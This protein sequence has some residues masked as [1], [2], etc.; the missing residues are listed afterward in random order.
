MFVDLC[1][2]PVK[3]PGSPFTHEGFK[4]VGLIFRDKGFVKFNFSQFSHTKRTY[5][6]NR[7]NKKSLILISHKEIECDRKQTTYKK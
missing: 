6:K 4:M 5:L 7:V 1:P 2:P 3:I